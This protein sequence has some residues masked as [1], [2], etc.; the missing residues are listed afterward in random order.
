[1]SKYK[2]SEKEEFGREVYRIK[3]INKSKASFKEIGDS[4]GIPGSTARRCYLDYVERMRNGTVK[5]VEETLEASE[6]KDH[7]ITELLTEEFNRLG[8]G[9]ETVKCRAYDKS[10]MGSDRWKYSIPLEIEIPAG[11]DPDER[12]LAFHAEALRNHL[13]LV[14]CD[15]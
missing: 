13:I 4:I 7:K 8:A 11:L 9:K 15:Y 2:E 14:E 10:T 12:E 5:N 3:D 1:M 6:E